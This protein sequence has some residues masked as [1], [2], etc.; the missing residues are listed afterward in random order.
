M[1][2]GE[3]VQRSYAAITTCF[4]CKLDQSN[5]STSTT[6][7]PK[8]PK[9]WCIS[10]RIKKETYHRLAELRVRNALRMGY[11]RMYGP[12]NLSGTAPFPFKPFDTTLKHELV[13]ILADCEAD[14]KVARE[15]LEIL[16]RAVSRGYQQMS[17][18]EKMIVIRKFGANVFKPVRAAGM[19]KEADKANTVGS[20]ASN[21]PGDTPS[22]LPLET[23]KTVSI[24]R[25]DL[26]ISHGLAAGQQDLRELRTDVDLYRKVWKEVKKMGY[27]DKR[28]LKQ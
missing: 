13:E 18:Y 24:S 11:Q 4:L 5:L 6:K 15:R 14:L 2:T 1:E 19:S 20:N 7:P 10:C 27:G 16:R 21:N 9:D 26:Q 28:R 25:I 12:F 8:R 17:G 23:S 3:I 22:P